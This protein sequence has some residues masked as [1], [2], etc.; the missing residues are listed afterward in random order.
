MSVL[1][2]F[3]YPEEKIADDVLETVEK[4]AREGHIDLED[5]CAIVKDDKG[6][7][8]LH[9]ETNLSFFGA[10]SGLVLGAF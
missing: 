4:L 2:A 7:I 5:A 6:K 1:L 3:I 10:I 9:Q 8:H